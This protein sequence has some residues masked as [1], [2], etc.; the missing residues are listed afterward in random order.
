MRVVVAP[1]KF[2]GSLTAPEAA[3]AM[4]RGVKA[5]APLASIDEVPMADGGE[6]TGNH[7]AVFMAEVATYAPA[8]AKGQGTDNK[9][10]PGNANFARHFGSLRLGFGFALRALGRHFRLLRVA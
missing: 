4:A 3:R 6:G 9:H 5:V 7:G 2:K 10:T 1:D 8:D